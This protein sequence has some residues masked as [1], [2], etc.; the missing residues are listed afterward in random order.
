MGFTMLCLYLLKRQIWSFMLTK[1]P[2]FNLG[3]KILG[4]VRMDLQDIW[5]IC[6]GEKK[7]TNDHRNLIS[8]LT[9][10]II[11]RTW[12]R[13]KIPVNTT[14]NQW[15]NDFCQR[16]KQLDEISRS[17]SSNGATVLRSSTVWLGGLFNPE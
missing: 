13:Y 8:D 5:M 10:G 1:T 4:T 2:S 17:V 14:V 15:I 12:L 6:R 3:C 9:R 7:Q 11:P 16:V